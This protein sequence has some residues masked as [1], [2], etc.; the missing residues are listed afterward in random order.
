MKFDWNQIN[1][2]T[3]HD[4]LK[5]NAGQDC[6]INSNKAQKCDIEDDFKID[7][8]DLNNVGGMTPNQP[9]HL[10]THVVTREQI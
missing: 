2:E 6:T 4:N 1:T 3:C 5:P 8:Y 7:M 10:G 9:R